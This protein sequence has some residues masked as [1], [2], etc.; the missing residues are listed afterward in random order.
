[1]KK[2]YFLCMAFI[3]VSLLLAAAA[4]A[5]AQVTAA[6]SDGG[7]D[8]VRLRVVNKSAAKVYLK[9]EGKPQYS[10]VVPS[11][12]TKEFTPERGSYSYT[13]T[14]CDQTSSGKMDLT[15]YRDL[16]VPACGGQLADSSNVHV[17]DL[18]PNLRPISLTVE[19]ANPKTVYVRL[20][21]PKT[22]NFKVAG[23][24]TSVFSVT[25]GNYSY[26][27]SAC[28]TSVE[29][30]VDLTK[31]QIMYI[32]VCGASPAGAADEHEVFISFNNLVKVNIANNSSA[33]FAVQLQGSKNY[34]LYIP[35]GKTKS[36]T[37]FRGEYKYEYIACG[38]MVR[39]KFEARKNAVLG[40]SCTG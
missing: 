38:N 12:S 23:K 27:V 16:I 37:M 4:P 31:Y 15:I 7:A 30:K 1:M 2:L 32:P 19:N 6:G 26:R 17:L 33:D 10:F 39:G 35:A 3:M 29:G 34:S 11:N 21:G 24:T 18:D 28:E 25:N 22:Y 36:F 8:L 14:A 20:T 5:P 40:L 9:L 13:L